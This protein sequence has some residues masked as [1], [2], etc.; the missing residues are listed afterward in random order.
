MTCRSSE[1][2]PG[3]LGLAPVSDLGRVFRGQV[4]FSSPVLGGGFAFLEGSFIAQP[5]TAAG[6]RRA[7]RD[8]TNIPAIQR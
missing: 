4:S 7:G 8:L 2:Q 5:A 1:H 6:R 3:E